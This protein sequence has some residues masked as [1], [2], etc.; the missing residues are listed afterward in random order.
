MD[1]IIPGKQITESQSWKLY[2]R[3]YSSFKWYPQGSI[4]GSI[5]FPIF[6]NDL[7]ELTN[8][9]CKV[10]ADDRK[11]YESAANGATIQEDSSS[12]VIHG[13]FI[14]IHLNV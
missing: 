10:F 1:E 6:I 7:P 4:L 2:I 9:T 12:G 5:L 14:S 3:S 8:S 13:I 11:L